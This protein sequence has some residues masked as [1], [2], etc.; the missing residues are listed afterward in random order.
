MAD[1]PQRTLKEDF[2]PLYHGILKSEGLK[3]LA[4]VFG[5]LCAFAVCVALW[6]GFNVYSKPGDSPDWTLIGIVVVGSFFLP[7]GLVQVIG[8][9][10]EGFSERGNSN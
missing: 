2:A 5:G 3:R 4:L 8:W 9:V 7:W 1:K 6:I 10:I